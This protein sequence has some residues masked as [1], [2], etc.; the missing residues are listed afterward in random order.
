MFCT[1]RA[2]IIVSM[3]R[4]LNA[5]AT[6]KSICDFGEVRKMVVGW[7]RREISGFGALCLVERQNFPLRG[8]TALSYIQVE[9]GLCL[10]R[11]QTR[12]CALLDD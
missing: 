2:A 5:I 12:S 6:K 7:R 4:D 9:N 11:A 1:A 10:F 8:A 3:R